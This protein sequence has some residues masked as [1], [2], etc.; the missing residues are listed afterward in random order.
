VSGRAWLDCCANLRLEGMK[1]RTKRK[2][3]LW[4][5]PVILQIQLLRH[6]FLPLVW[7]VYFILLHIIYKDYI[8][9]PP[10]TLFFSSHG[11]F[12][13]A[14]TVISLLLYWSSIE[15]SSKFTNQSYSIGKWDQNML[16]AIICHQHLGNIFEWQ[17]YPYRYDFL[18][19]LLV[20]P[21]RYCQWQ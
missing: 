21:T 12:G 5:G 7:F 2:A 9:P 19:P 16:D 3:D 15:F 17:Q 8:F 13:R 14:G 10:T 6:I 20:L 11:L 18:G 1:K 4:M